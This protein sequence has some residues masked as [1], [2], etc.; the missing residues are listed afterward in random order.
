MPVDSFRFLPRLIATFY[1]MTGR[2]AIHPVPWTPLPGPVADCKFALITSA[3]LYCRSQDS[4][5][6][7]ALE[8]EQP[9]WGDPTYR[10]IPTATRQEEITVSH[11]HLNYADIEQ[12]MN[13][14]LP[15]HRCQ[16]LA[17]DGRIGSLAGTHYSFMGF[18][19]FPPDA[20]LWETKYGPE[21]A[22]RLQAEEVQC[23]LLTPA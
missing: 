18:Q 19:G 8:R 15:I 6:D 7:V 5:F 14:V 13:I 10:T 1:K 16:E 21:V 2:E 12:D 11:L 3:G 22:G 17:A 20:T 23:V 9:D 4:P